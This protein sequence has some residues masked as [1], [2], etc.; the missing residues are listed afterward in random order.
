MWER[1]V[2][3]CIDSIC[4]SI[5]DIADMGTNFENSDISIQ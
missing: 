2:R 1:C 4:L 3:I 5:P